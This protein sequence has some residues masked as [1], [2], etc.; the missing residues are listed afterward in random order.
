MLQVRLNHCNLA[1]GADGQT[2]GPFPVPN[3]TFQCHCII[4]VLFTQHFGVPRLL[5]SVA[6]SCM[7]PKVR[8]AESADVR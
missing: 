5:D 4:W 1:R 6:R 8:E 2:C 7:Q 3:S